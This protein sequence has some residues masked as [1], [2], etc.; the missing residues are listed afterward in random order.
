MK[1]LIN[2]GW[3]I[4]N[5][6]Y[7]TAFN[8]VPCTVLGSLLKNKIIE[9]PYYRDNEEK[10]KKIL[11]DDFTFINHFSLSEKQIHSPLFL[12]FDGICTVADIYIN[13]V[14]ISKTYDMHQRYKFKIDNNLLKTNNELKIEFKSSIQYVRNYP[15]EKGLFRSFAVTDPDSPKLRQSNAMFGWDWGPTLPDMGLFRDVYLISTSNGY[16]DNI[17]PHYK[18]NNDSVKIDI[19]INL[20]LLNNSKLS[21]VLEGFGY[22]NKIEITAKNAKETAHFEINNPKLWYPTGYGEQNLYKLT[23]CFDDELYTYDIGVRE[24][25]IDD[26]YDE[27]GRNYAVYVNGVK[28]FIKGGNYIPEDI[29]LD[30]ININRS[31]KLLN[32]AKSFNHNAIRIWG[33]GTYLDD[34]FYQI[35]DKEGILVFHDLMFA[36]ATYDIED[37]FFKSLIESETRDAL[38]RLRS[39]TSII[40]ISGN[41]EVE[42]EVRGN[43]VKLAEQYLV[44]YHDFISKIVKEECEIKFFTS[45]PTS[46]E[47][48]FSSPNDTNYLDTHSWWVWGNKYP[49][50]FYETIKPRFLSEFG[51]QSFATYDTILGFCDKEDLSIFSDIMTWH[52]KDRSKTNQKIYDYVCELYKVSEDL[53]SFTYL[54]MLMQ[55]EAIKLCVENIRQN[56]DRCNGLLYWQLNDC[57]P[58]HSWSSIDYNY[59]LKALHYYSKHFFNPDLVSVD[60]KNDKVIVFLS[61]DHQYERKYKLKYSYIDLD[62]TTNYE[63]KLF[64]INKYQSKDVLSLEKNN[65]LGIYVS[66]FDENDNLLNENHFLFKK[67]KDISYLK[68]NIKIDVIDN[69]SFKVSTDNFAR[70]IYLNFHD[71]EVILS[72]NFFSL[73]PNENKV[74]TSNK[75]LDYKKLEIICLNNIY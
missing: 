39:H 33:G 25:Y 11:E 36:C 47:P 6:K 16:V 42:D 22:K 30:R 1:I 10:A 23:I 54:S 18:F 59:G 9:D 21:V 37:S 55:A 43:G 15:N 63:T 49:I 71:F 64:L 57:W 20:C 19:D 31:K 48:Y 13:D 4:K 45:S 74:I 5:N 72:D 60:I 17:F 27:F 35:C 66:L 65:H 50:S 7:D 62:K 3:Q 56:K 32:L 14:L 40:V 24:I 70:S 67:D 34:H 44:M 53:K 68:A 51:M 61:N 58:G 69:K 2:S 52:E 29:L 41:N 12:C 73:N 46:G 26:S 75:E 38:R 8:D 28:I